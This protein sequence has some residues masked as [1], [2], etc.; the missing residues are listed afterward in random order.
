MQVGKIVSYLYGLISVCNAK[1]NAAKGRAEQTLI[2]LRLRTTETIC[3]GDVTREAHVCLCRELC[4]LPKPYLDAPNTRSA[5]PN[6]AVRA[7]VYL[8]VPTH[9][10][11]CQDSDGCVTRRPH[12]A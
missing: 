3:H 2:G 11:P 4:L 6:R 10:P 1:T 12:S 5:T 8:L 9:K 7:L